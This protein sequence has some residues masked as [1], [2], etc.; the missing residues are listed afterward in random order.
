M[1]R[2]LGVNGRRDV[3]QVSTD[4]CY[5]LC[6]LTSLLFVG[7]VQASGRD[8]LFERLDPGTGSRVAKVT[9]TV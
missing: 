5:L 4:L 9:I 8:W 7:L 3:F 1:T 2:K 6:A